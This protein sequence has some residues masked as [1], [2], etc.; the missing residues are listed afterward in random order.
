MS[1]ISE[2]QQSEVMRITN[3]S[4]DNFASLSSNGQI[5][6]RDSI[7]SGGING[8]ILVGTTAIE[9]KVG[10]T[11]LDNRKNLTVYNNSKKNIYWGYSN[12]V[13]V[14]TGTPLSTGEMIIVK[15]EPDVEIWVISED[16]LL[17]VR[18]TEAP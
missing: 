12:S 16:P 1:D 10:A 5:H 7:S 8:S 17:D 9:A 3:E 18:V 15:G 6:V 11:R 2:N 13:S 14:S 4:E